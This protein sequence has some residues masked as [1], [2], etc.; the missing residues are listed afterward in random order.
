MA[1][2]KS[3]YVI[4]RGVE[5]CTRANAEC[6]AMLIEPRGVINTG[7]AD[8]QLTAKNDVWI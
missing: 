1:L 5:H 4:P 6:K 7:D 8:S 2:W 3:N